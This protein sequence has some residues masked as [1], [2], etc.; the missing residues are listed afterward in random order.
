MKT[1]VANESKANCLKAIVRTTTDA[2]KVGIYTA[3]DKAMI[4]PLCTAGGALGD[5][6][7]ALLESSTTTST[8][9]VAPLSVSLSQCYESFLQSVLSRN[10]Q[11]RILS[12]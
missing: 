6:I 5:V 12:V 3:A 1:A 8:Q 10:D 9:K 4:V 7:I 2:I 11:L